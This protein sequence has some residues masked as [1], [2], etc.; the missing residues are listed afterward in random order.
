MKSSVV[1]LAVVLALLG[2][3]AALAASGVGTLVTGGEDGAVNG[4]A[5]QQPLGAI[6]AT[7]NAVTGQGNV[8]PN[9][10]TGNVQ[11]QGRSNTAAVGASAGT[12]VGNAAQ[13]GSQLPFS[14]YLAMSVLLAGSALLLAG[15][16][17]RRRTAQPA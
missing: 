3:G 9:T 4:R 16:A 13:T 11:N 10:N 8:S 1:L 14:G 5:A 7:P 15:F 2:A 12:A 6:S 17:L